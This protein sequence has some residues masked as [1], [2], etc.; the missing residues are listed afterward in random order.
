MARTRSNSRA[1][2]MDGAVGRKR[3]LGPVLYAISGVGELQMLPFTIL[4]F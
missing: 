3:G 2:C 4:G 1:F